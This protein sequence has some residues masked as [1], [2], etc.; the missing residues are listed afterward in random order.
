MLNLQRTEKAAHQ[1]KQIINKT[2]NSNLNRIK[3]ENGIDERKEI[4]FIANENIRLLMSASINAKRCFVIMPFSDTE[5]HTKIYWNKHFLNFLKPLIESCNVQA[6]RSVP[7]RQNTLRQIVNDLV[8]SPIVVAELTDATPSVFWELGVRQ[9]FRH[10]T[11]TI[12]DSSFKIPFDISSKGI[13][14]YS[15]EPATR[16]SFSKSFKEAI[17]DFLA[18][19]SRP[20]SEVLESITGRTSIY[21]TIH[22]EEMVRKVE[23][24][25]SESKMNC[26]ILAVILNRILENKHKTA[27]SVRGKTTVITRLSSSSLGLLLTE[28]YLEQPSDFYKVAHRLLI[29]IHAVNH[30]ISTWDRGKTTEKWFDENGTIMKQSYE[31]FIAILEEIYKAL[32]SNC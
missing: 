30:E 7:L 13:L 28:R 25:I 29:L 24:L 26:E 12:A 11:I 10:G 4:D 22:R 18:N 32:L 3:L 21:A 6:F 19:P 5:S 23:G 9:S 14:R 8:Y 1:T 17:N 27:F 31:E 15:S 20:D 2:T 16:E